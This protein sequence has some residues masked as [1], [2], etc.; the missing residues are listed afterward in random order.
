MDEEL[1]PRQMMQI[2]QSIVNCLAAARVE[3]YRQVLYRLDKLG[4]QLARI[5]AVS[6]KLGLAVGRW[7]YAAAEQGQLDRP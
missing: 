4:T 3:R 6:R 1:S 2:A 5:H 7:W